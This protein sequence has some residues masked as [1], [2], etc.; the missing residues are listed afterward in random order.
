[1]KYWRELVIFGELTILL[2]FVPRLA[3]YNYYFDGPILIEHF[4]YKHTH[5]IGEIHVRIIW[6]FSHTYIAN[7]PNLILHQYFMPYGN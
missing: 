6:W 5:I 7:L 1:M 2:I 4:T 3:D